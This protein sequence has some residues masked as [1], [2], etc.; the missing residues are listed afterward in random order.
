MVGVFANSEQGH[1]SSTRPP[2][3]SVL[4]VF[5]S[6]PRPL[7]TR[8][9]QDA[10]ISKSQISLKC[11]RRIPGS[12]LGTPYAV[13]LTK[14]ITYPFNFLMTSITRVQLRWGNSHGKRRYGLL[15]RQWQGLGGVMRRLVYRTPKFSAPFFIRSR[16]SRNFQYFFCLCFEFPNLESYELIM[17][18]VLHIRR[19]LIEE[20]CWTVE[21]SAEWVLSVPHVQAWLVSTQSYA[22][23]P[24]RVPLVT[25]FILKISPW[26][27]PAPSA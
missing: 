24:G 23:L 15:R 3:P 14:A 2:S 6:S 5:A 17:Y 12:P 16:K 27:V 13:L 8:H 4:L 1:H 7:D 19:F 9:S 21:I 18:S 25:V 11:V 22:R 20:R 10:S 26:Q